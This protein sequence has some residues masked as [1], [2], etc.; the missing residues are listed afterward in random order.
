MKKRAFERIPVNLK[1]EY[2]YG[3]ETTYGT[4]T[5]LS[6][7]GMLVTTK[8]CFPIHSKFEILFPLGD[9]VLNIP[10]KVSRVVKSGAFYDGMGVALL[11]PPKKYLEFVSRLEWNHIKNAKFEAQ[12]L[13]I[14][15]C[16]VCRHTAFEYQPITCPICGAPIEKFEHKPEVLKTVGDF[17]LLGEF[18]KKHFPL[19]N[20]SKEQN[21]LPY[22]KYVDVHAKVGEIAHAMDTEDHITFIDFYF[23]NFSL[24]KRFIARVSLNCN[25]MFPEAILRLNNA[26]TGVLT[27]IGN[28]SAHGSWL[29]EAAL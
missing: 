14:F 15:V 20:I 26:A 13:K 28:C 18:E 9:E 12:K 16:K 22:Y 10:V 17:E 3:D 25:I 2:L 8:V 1:V 23:N 27:V 6:K 4:I 19:I 29:T 21:S 24:N 5:N 11:T 7:N